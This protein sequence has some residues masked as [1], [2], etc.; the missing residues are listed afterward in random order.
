[1]LLNKYQNTW[2]ILRAIYI[3]TICTFIF[4]FDF[5]SF[6]WFKHVPKTVLGPK[7]WVDNFVFRIF[8]GILVVPPFWWV[9][10][11]R[12]FKHTRTRQQWIDCLGKTRNATSSFVLALMMWTMLHISYI[13]SPPFLPF[14]SLSNHPWQKYS[15]NTWHPFM[16]HWFLTL[17]PG[18]SLFSFFSISTPPL[19]IPPAKLLTCQVYV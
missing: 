3:T 13:Q 5:G 15:F 14:F 12:C 19:M 2:Y 4:C 18:R 7:V 8:K 6:T 1:M 10:I 11:Y 9:M 16:F 17:L